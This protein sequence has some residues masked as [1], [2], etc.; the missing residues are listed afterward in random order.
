MVFYE[1]ALKV[2][3]R[4]RISDSR[5]YLRKSGWQR[6]NKPDFSFNESLIMGGLCHWLCNFSYEHFIL[7]YGL[8]TGI[9]THRL[10]HELA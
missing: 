6:R 2:P 1:M 7:T 10:G 9:E 3:Q 5:G 4:I 8:G